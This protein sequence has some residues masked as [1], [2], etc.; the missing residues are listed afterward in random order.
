MTHRFA[1]HRAV[2]PMM[3]V[4]VALAALEMAIVHGLVAVWWPWVAVAL[5][6]AT[7]PAIAWLV[8]AI[9][10]FRRLPV[11]IEGDRI[12]LRVGT[13]RSVAFDRRDIAALRCS[14]WTAAEIKARSTF[15]LALIAYPNVMVDLRAPLTLGG[16]RAIRTIAHRLDDPAGFAGALEPLGAGHDR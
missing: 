5:S 9:L 10:S 15:N 7:L 13:I 1:Y 3:W 11:L 2:A 8:H 6:A 12:V 16:G 4:L 14:G